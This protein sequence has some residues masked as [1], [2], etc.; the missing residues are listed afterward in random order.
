MFYSFADEFFRVT[1]RRVSDSIIQ[2]F[3]LSSQVEGL[4]RAIEDCSYEAEE[5][6]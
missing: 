2:R 1:P 6:C 5:V 4:R 3:A